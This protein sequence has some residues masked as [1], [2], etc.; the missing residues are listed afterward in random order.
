MWFRLLRSGSL[1]K[2]NLPRLHK[3][4]WKQKQF[5]QANLQ[6]LYAY[7]CYSNAVLKDEFSEYLLYLKAL[8]NDNLTTKDMKN[9]SHFP[10]NLLA[11]LGGQSSNSYIQLQNVVEL[12]EEFLQKQ[13]ELLELKAF[14]A[15]N[16]LDEEMISEVKSEQNDLKN[17]VQDLHENLIDVLIQDQEL[18][19][20]E[21]AL[22]EVIPG[23]G[24]A[25]AML[26][27][28]DLFTMY[29]N[30]CNTQG[31]D[32]Q[33]ITYNEHNYGGI[34][35]AS[36]AVLSSDAYKLLRYE[37]G[38]H[39]VQRVPETSKG[40]IHTSTATVAV[41]PKQVQVQQEIDMKDLD[42]TYS[43]S[44]GPGGQSVNTTNSAVQI[45]HKPS[46]I[47]VRC[48]VTR[49]Q[50]E[51]YRLAMMEVTQKLHSK[52][53]AEKLAKDTS[54]RSMQI[55]QR[56]RS[57]K[58]R[59]YNF[60]RDRVTDH[61]IAYSMHGMQSI[62]N[63]GSKLLQLMKTLDEHYAKETKMAILKGLIDEYTLINKASNKK[64]AK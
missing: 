39:R 25:E 29:E 4:V 41:L 45:N 15:D 64:K 11:E 48:E 17:S 53:K 14:A 56:D 42:I 62:L 44:S 19:D 38:T 21:G 6:R 2:E 30:F 9:V 57:D 35:N 32:W 8:L 46:G 24:G 5:P 27:A 55:K 36:A 26:F 12:G 47:K 23:V 28:R 31:F 22:L 40:Q 50:R 59:T 3:F 16:E 52:L 61:R 63:N 10:P 43:R 58:I 51:N 20:C 18:E 33:I 34:L 49:N 13:S 60:M 7:R 54:V 37:A 1:W